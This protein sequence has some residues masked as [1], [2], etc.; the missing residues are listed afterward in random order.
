M[1]QIISFLQT[2]AAKLGAVPKKPPVSKDIKVIKDIQDIKDAK[3]IKDIKDA[4]VT[5]DV[6]SIPEESR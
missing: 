1:L 5:E 3:V 4:N 6:K 2:V